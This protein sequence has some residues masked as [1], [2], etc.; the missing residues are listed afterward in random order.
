MSLLVDA[1]FEQVERSPNKTALWCEDRSVSYETFARHVDK[2]TAHF[3]R[4]GVRNGDHIGVLLPNSIE[5]VEVLLAAARI[6]AAIAP[7]STGLPLDAIRRAFE[8]SDVTHLVAND[9]N[10]AKIGRDGVPCLTGM[11]LCV[12]PSSTG[13]VTYQECLENQAL[14]VP[15]IESPAGNSALILTLTSGSTGDPKPI[16]LTQDNKHD[17]ALSAM[18]CY[19]VTEDD[20]ILAATPLY[21]SLAM[22]LV[23]LPLICGATGILMPRF[24][25]SEWLKTVHDR[26]VSF[27][28]AVSSQLN[29]IAEV[30]SSPFLPD[31]DS[32][33]CVVSSSAFLPNHVKSELLAKLRCDFH[34]CYGTS[35]IAVATNL[36]LQDYREKLGSVGRSI[37]EAEV[38]IL[39][40]DGTLA[41]CGETGQ[42]LCKTSLLFAGYY[43]Q[44]EQTRDAMWNDYFLTG[45]VGYL[46][47]DG[48]LY[49]QGRSKDIIISGGVN[50][51]PS[52]VEEVI[53]TLES[54]K[55]CAAFAFPDK[56]LGEVVAVA[57]VPREGQRFDERQARLLC[58]RRLA[59][60][61]QPRRFFVTEKLPGNQ[62]GK[63]VKHKLRDLFS[64]AE[65]A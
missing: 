3:H 30:L 47:E 54:V 25:P 35:E 33:R 37:D 6:G 21:H 42:I 55:T 43:K 60:F 41:A 13:A 45:D 40:E 49:F 17:R 61:Q 57:V 2:L 10:L 53:A 64:E 34:E 51:Y 27:T 18:K 44:P 46:D 39:K 4:N 38:R 59:D 23:L 20:V 48:F 15:P 8:A 29:K 65:E 12:G 14:G 63:L 50:I 22:R 19:E 1:I 36:N 56:V 16:V 9:Y 7:L 24:S 52:D 32:L 5:F 11:R 26:R 31:I 62:M 28:I 58:A